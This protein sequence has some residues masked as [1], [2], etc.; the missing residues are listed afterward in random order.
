ML[1][2]LVCSTFKAP[3]VNTFVTPIHMHRCVA[4]PLIDSASLSQSAM[5]NNQNVSAVSY[6][7]TWQFNQ[8][9]CLSVCVSLSVCVCVWLFKCQNWLQI[10]MRDSI[11][12]SLHIYLGSA[13]NWGNLAILHIEWKSL[14]AT[15]A[16]LYKYRENNTLSLHKYGLYFLKNHNK[17]HTTE[18]R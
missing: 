18:G 17:Q 2:H 15:A 11:G 5:I 10:C 1:S 12:Q 16:C 13:Y 4:V 14:L 6:K 8:F 3:L 7:V 9:V